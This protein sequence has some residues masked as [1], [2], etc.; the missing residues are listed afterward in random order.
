MLELVRERVPPKH[1]ELESA[2]DRVILSHCD[3]WGNPSADRKAYVKRA[4]VT[5]QYLESGSHMGR[6]TV[7]CGGCSCAAT[8]ACSSRAA[9]RTQ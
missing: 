2:V 4:P 6:A 7:T 8:D 3:R 1:E 5:L 9:Q